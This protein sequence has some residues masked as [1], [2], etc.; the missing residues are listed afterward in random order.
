MIQGHSWVS[1]VTNMW[2]IVG[3]MNFEW[4]HNSK[5][6]L[7]TIIIG[8]KDEL[9][10][11]MKKGIVAFPSHRIRIRSKAM[12]AQWYKNEEEEE[13]EEAEEE[14]KIKYEQNI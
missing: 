3:I 5:K 8:G 11:S 2:Y 10:I 14:Y 13:A 9:N 4:M 1:F 12:D 6:Q 7:Q